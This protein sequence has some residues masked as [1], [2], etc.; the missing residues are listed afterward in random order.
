[1]DDA[2]LDQ[3]HKPIHDLLQH[4]HRLLLVDKGGHLHVL[5]EVAVA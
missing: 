2:L 4:F 3:C 1:M 5:L